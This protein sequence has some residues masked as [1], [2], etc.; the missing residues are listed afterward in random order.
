VSAFPYLALGAGIGTTL[1]VLCCFPRAALT[2]VTLGL[3]VAAAWAATD[4]AYFAATVLGLE[5]VA[6]G[7]MGFECART[8]AKFDAND[9]A[10][11]SRTRDAAAS[12]GTSR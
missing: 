5:A 3:A 2:L 12:Q 7:W 4:G 10:L 8:V 11:A 1:F 9:A 6:I